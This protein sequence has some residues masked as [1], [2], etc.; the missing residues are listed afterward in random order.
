MDQA[1]L[2]LYFDNVQDFDAVY[3][4]DSRLAEPVGPRN[5]ILLSDN[6]GES[7]DDRPSESL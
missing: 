7:S 6:I 4:S 3:T 5:Q 1:R 2:N